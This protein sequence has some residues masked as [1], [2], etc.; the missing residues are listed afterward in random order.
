MQG[1]I[2]SDPPLIDGKPVEV[3]VRVGVSNLG[4]IDTV[5][6]TVRSFSNVRLFVDSDASMQA[7][8]KFFLD[9]YW[10][11]SS[12]IGLDRESV[13]SYIWRPDAYVFNGM[14]AGNCCCQR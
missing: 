8:V 5:N 13:P 10:H 12:L 1:D 6:Q 4:N 7:A 3:Q 9:L 2:H 14:G 11:D